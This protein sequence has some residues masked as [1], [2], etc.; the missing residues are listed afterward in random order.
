MNP[1]DLLTQAHACGAVLV[2]D[3]GRLRV[4]NSRTLPA[5]LRQAITDHRTAI[6]DLL[7]IPHAPKPA[8]QATFGERVTVTNHGE[9]VAATLAMFPGSKVV[10]LQLYEPL[11]PEVLEAALLRFASLTIT[12]LPDET[13]EQRSREAIRCLAFIL[14]RPPDASERIIEAAQSYFGAI[15]KMSR[16]ELLE[17]ARLLNERKHLMSPEEYKRELDRIV[18]LSM[19]ED[20]R[21]FG[22]DKPWQG[23]LG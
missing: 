8:V 4:K 9:L 15:E 19:R 11:T 3:G 6:L 13:P 21:L 5:D 2:A 16:E 17:Q 23:G 1:T 20:E 18:E 22:P 12:T 14:N 7:E 10:D